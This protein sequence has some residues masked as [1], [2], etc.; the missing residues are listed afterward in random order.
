MSNS[1]LRTLLLIAKPLY[2]IL[3]MRLLLICLVAFSC[4]QCS[5]YTDKDCDTTAVLFGAD[6]TKCGCCR[7]WQLQIGDETFLTDSIPQIGLL[8]NSEV[9]DDLPYV[10]SIGYFGSMSS[11]SNRIDIQCAI[12]K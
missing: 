4:L 3:I 2:S 1:A 9:P 6:F 11:F 10:L 7:G 12:R 8:K 5:S